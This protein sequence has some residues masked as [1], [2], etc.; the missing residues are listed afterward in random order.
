ML[1]LGFRFDPEGNRRR[2]KLL[3]HLSICPFH[4]SAWISYVLERS[5]WQLYENGC[6]Y[7]GQV[8]NEA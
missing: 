1:P 7:V 2:F 8:Q 4:G 6:G 3:V 5:L